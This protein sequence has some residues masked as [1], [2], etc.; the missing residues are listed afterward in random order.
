MSAHRSRA[1][2]RPLTRRDFTRNT[3]AGSA[4]LGA[5]GALLAGCGGDD[6]GDG[7]PVTLRFW[8]F[9]AADDGA[10][11]RIEEA[12]DVWNDENP[13]VQVQFETFPFEDYTTT[14]LTTA[15]AANRGPD[16][17]WI[18]PGAFI[19][20]VNQGVAAPI[21]DIVDPT[22][23]NEPSIAAVTV[24]GQMMS[25]PFEMEPVGLFYRL[26]HLA[27]AGIDPPR[28]WDDLVAAAEELTGGGRHGVVIETGTGPYQNF[29]WYPF[30]WSAGG[31][32]VNAESTASALRTPEAASAFDLWGQLVTRGFAPER[33][34]EGT[35]NP[36]PLGRGETAMQVCGFWA[37]SILQNL[38]DDV[39]FGIVPIPAPQGGEP[40][41]VYGGWTQ[42]INAGSSHIEAAKAFTEWL[43]VAN[44]DFSEDWA[45]RLGSKY[46]PRHAVNE[47]C[48]DVFDADPHR[49]FTEQILPTAR[50]EP[51]Y[52]DRVVRAVG[53][54][55][56]AAMFRGASGDDAA[57]LAADQIDAF[58][59]TYDGAPLNAET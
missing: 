23:Y 22:E 15:F 48:A 39:P 1:G 56:E 57:A 42:M 10:D 26:D 9:N 30:L 34:E 32:V 37:I 21:G 16:I 4:S 25:L 18:S 3:L 28:T 8:K 46:S 24:D 14:T 12:I 45:C 6:G 2:G 33:T 59:D 58:L 29:T 27:D 31:E 43:W 5:L 52:P 17:F 38:Y 20:Y 50:A 51:R 19:D 13:D 41:T 35:N 54:G 11:P 44:D 49:A 55:L 47:A 7:G 40:V 53:D 36:G